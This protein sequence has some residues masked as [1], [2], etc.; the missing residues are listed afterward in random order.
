LGRED[1]KGLTDV[2]LMTD[3]L[4]AAT[5][6]EYGLPLL[7]SE[8]GTCAVVYDG[9]E[10]Q[11]RSDVSVWRAIDVSEMMQGVQSEWKP[12]HW[13]FSYNNIQ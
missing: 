8:D 5:A 1:E 4:I 9:T 13:P 3:A 2:M 12:K 11:Q 7:T 6:V 10:R